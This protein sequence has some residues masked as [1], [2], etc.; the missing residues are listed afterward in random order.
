[1]MGYMSSRKAYY[2]TILLKM[3]IWGGKNL[4]IIISAATHRSGSTLLQRIF[5]VRKKTLIWGEQDGLLTNFHIIYSNLKHYSVDLSQQRLD[6]FNNNEDPNHWI[7]CMNPEMEIIDKAV[8]NSIKVLFHSLYELGQGEHDIIGFKEVRYG[9]E[10]L[11]LY[12]KCYPNTKIIL[13]VRHPV[14]VWKSM[15]GAGLGGNVSLFTR[16]WNKHASYYHQFAKSDPNSFL[17]KYEDI[18]NKEPNT[19]NTIAQLGQLSLEEINKVLPKKIFSTPREI[20]PEIENFILK[21]CGEIM[22]LYGYR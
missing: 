7:A 12:R 9:E 1:M 3:N 10:E 4:D 20:T 16:K 19:L 8:T 15:L 2:N 21:V 22:K 11:T 18:I 6:Y 13:L 5:N 14:N 17:I